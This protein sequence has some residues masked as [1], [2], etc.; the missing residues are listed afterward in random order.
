[1]PSMGG[2]MDAF[3]KVIGQYILSIAKPDW[4]YW[5]QEQAYARFNPAATA[6]PAG[7]VLPVSPGQQATLGSCPAGYSIFWLQKTGRIQ[8]RGCE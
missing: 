7:L 3:Q 4:Q 1:M 2:K 6:D 5:I 8:C